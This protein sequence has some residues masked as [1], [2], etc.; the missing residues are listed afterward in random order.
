MWIGEWGMGRGMTARWEQPI[1]A[2]E[3]TL[4]R[5][6]FC[7][8]GG[9]G[10]TI[11][12]GQCFGESGVNRRVSWAGLSLDCHLSL[13]AAARESWEG[14]GFS[15]KGAKARR[16]KFK[17]EISDFK[18]GGPGAAGGL[19]ADGAK[20]KVIGFCHDLEKID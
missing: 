3:T 1:V 9:I 2:C 17:F 6:D 14:E 12:R 13:R 10:R 16:R 20:W 4:R 8:L 7:A 18:G 5:T 19:H 15:R 11:S